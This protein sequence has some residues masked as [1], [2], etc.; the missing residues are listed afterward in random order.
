[1]SN[2]K[3]RILDAA[4]RAF[5]E[6]GIDGASLRFITGEAGA[7]LGS[8]HYYFGSKEVLV[9]DV[10]HRRMNEFNR[11]REAQLRQIGQGQ[12]PS[13]L[14][15][16]WW[17]LTRAITEFQKKYPDFVRFIERL[18]WSEDTRFLEMVQDKELEF[19]QAF[20]AMVQEHFP[21]E[22]AGPVKE[23]SVLL[24]HMINHAIL[25]R[26]LLEKTLKEKQI[27]L[28]DEQIAENMADIAVGALAEFQAKP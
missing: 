13:S 16:K 4:E 10:F 23:R 24:I 28:D 5:A 22:L 9:L 26:F 27:N 17:S 21:P 25:N 6:K 2:T 8:I 7:N 20:L 15:A 18:L 11:A 12:Q 14:R 1:M 19:D 3:E